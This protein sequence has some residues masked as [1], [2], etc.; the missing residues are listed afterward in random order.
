MS[1]PSKFKLKAKRFVAYFDVLGFKD[2]VYR[3]SHSDVA[4]KMDVIGEVVE[5]IKE[6]E[7]EN[8][9]KYNW[10]RKR[11]FHKGIVLPVM[12]SD[13][14]L[15]VS[16]SDKIYDAYKMI[17][18]TSYFMNKMFLASIPIKGCLAYGEFTADFEKSIFFGRPLIDAFYLSEETYFLGATL[19]HTFEKF[20]KDKKLNPPIEI[21][22]ESALPMKNGLI[23]HK[24]IDWRANSPEDEN[25]K[26]IIEDFYKNVSG[27]ARKY[28][29][30]SLIVY[31]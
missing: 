9:L 2:M 30:N 16:Y 24:F 1:R 10:N 13:S 27:S 31:I 18:A 22:K 23:H 11:S 8:L 28:I 7:T 20:L 5:I 6:V 26:A 12:F 4:E 25:S 14:I 21:V 17:H 29:D 3:N 15:F 19:H